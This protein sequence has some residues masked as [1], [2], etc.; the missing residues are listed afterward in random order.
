MCERPYVEKDKL[1]DNMKLI[2]YFSQHVFPGT[3]ISSALKSTATTNYDGGSSSPNTGQ[4]SASA[5]VP[6]QIL[7]RTSP[8]VQRGDSFASPKKTIEGGGGSAS[9]SAGSSASTASK[10]AGAGGGGGGYHGNRQNPN[11]ANKSA[12][13]YSH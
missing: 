3:S 13:N 4:S 9:T 11:S 10:S 8:P 12:K 5:V 2:F 1:N 7:H 6:K